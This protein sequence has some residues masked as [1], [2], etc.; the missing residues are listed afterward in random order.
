VWVA[1][2]IA[3]VALVFGLAHLPA[4]AALTSL[5]LPLAAGVIVVNG[6]VA[7]ALGALYWRPGI[8]AAIIAHIVADAT[9]RGLGP[10]LLR[11]SPAMAA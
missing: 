9:L 5:T 10:W 3:L 6:V 2:N 7:L 11:L 1:L 4:W 8:V